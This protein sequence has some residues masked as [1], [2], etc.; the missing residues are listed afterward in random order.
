MAADHG[1]SKELQER[2]REDR[3]CHWVKIPVPL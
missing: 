2:I 1:L 3:R